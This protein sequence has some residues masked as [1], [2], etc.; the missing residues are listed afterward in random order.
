[1]SRLLYVF[2][3]LSA[4]CAASTGCRKLDDK[5][6][7]PPGDSTAVKADT[8]AAHL[9]FVNAE[10]KSGSMPAGPAASS[11]KISIPDTLSL[12]DGFKIPISF[13]HM[14]T[15]KDVSGAF[16]KVYN[17]GIGGTFYY[18]VPEVPDVAGN[19]TVSTILI[20]IDP[21]GLENLP[22]VPPAG[23]G[24][25]FVIKVIPHGPDGNPLAE[26]D[27]PVEIVEPASDP[28]GGRCG[29]VT[30]Q[31]EYWEWTSSY[32]DI[33]DANGKY[34]FYNSPDKL[35]GLEK[36]STGQRIR[37]CCTNGISS[38]NSRCDSSNFRYL[39]FRTFFGWPNEIYK[40]M[41]DGTYAG[42]TEFLSADPDPESSNFCDTKPGIVVEDFDRSFLSGTWTLTSGVL[43]TLGTSTPQAG[44][45]AA[46]PDGVI[47]VAN[48]LF[49]II[50]AP[51][52]EGGGRNLT[53]VYRRRNSSAP[54]WKPI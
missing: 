9:R 53:K 28:A 31:G 18:D 2:L 3:M 13:L 6:V 46:R 22:G 43:S 20:G 21:K 51:D 23:A 1:M 41:P 10:K 52:R 38:Y 32:I 14:D 29:L 39:N 5:P 4:M 17:G 30:A 54:D 8:I 40:F 49:L 47:K 24:P 50:V 48:C 33:A 25:P 36:N 34:V 12:F 7:E 15:T 11:L 44:S 45:L 35:W 16:I 27:I 26:E 37:G 19:D 42:M